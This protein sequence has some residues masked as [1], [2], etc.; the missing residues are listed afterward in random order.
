M[1]RRVIFTIIA[2]G[3]ILLVAI[4]ATVWQGSAWVPGASDT[5]DEFE[6]LQAVP[7]SRNPRYAAVYR[8]FHANSSSTMTAVWILT[9]QPRP[10][11]SKV[12]VAGDPVLVF[13]GRPEAVRVQWATD[14]SRLRVEL[15][16]MTDVRTGA[17][18]FE[19][20]YFAD[21]RVSNLACYD[22]KQ[23]ELR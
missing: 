13:T 14:S 10:I 17:A 4:A 18:A 7:D 15:D 16:G 20:C 11:G 6:L 9:G 5:A 22:D 1:P 3:L 21:R 23:I 8:Y 2:A 12:P 19:D